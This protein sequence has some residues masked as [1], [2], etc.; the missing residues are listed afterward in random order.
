LNGQPRVIVF[1]E[2][3]GRRHAHCV[4]SRISTSSHGGEERIGGFDP[5]RICQRG[6]FRLR[7]V[8]REQAFALLSV[9]HGVAFLEG[10]F[11]L[12][13]RAVL[14]R[15]G[16]GDGVGINH[17]FAGLPFFTCPLSSN[18]CLKVNHN[19]QAKPFAT[20]ADHS[21]TTLMPR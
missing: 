16:A 20:D 3:N 7:I 2:K 6:A 19:G 8:M 4:W 11:P 10:D 21:I 9:E 15:L 1:H 12:L 17:K 14:L 13:F 5:L 18:F